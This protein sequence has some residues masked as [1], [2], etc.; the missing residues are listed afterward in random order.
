MKRKLE[1]P[2]DSVNI[3]N[4]ISNTPDKCD[5]T[6]HNL[7]ISLI[8][9]MF[10]GSARAG[11]IDKDNPVR[12]SS[13]RGNLRF[14]WRAT[15]GAA[16]KNV[17]ELSKRETEIF[18]NTSTPSSIHIWIERVGKDISLD[19]AQIHSGRKNEFVK[20]LPK[21][22]MFPFDKNTEIKFGS[23]Y[24]FS[25]RITVNSTDKELYEKEIEP[26][27]WAWINF[28]GVGAR[29]R[30][31]CGSL[32]S[33]KFSPKRGENIKD[34]YKQ[35]IAG[36]ELQLPITD[37]GPGNQQWPILCD[38]IK[39]SKTEETISDAWNKIAKLYSDFRRAPCMKYG[40]VSND[41]VLKRSFWPEAD[42]I[43]EITGMSKK[44]HKTS[45]TIDK[46]EY[47]FPRAQLGLPIQ[48]QFA[49]RRVSHE[50]KLNEPF[51]TK[52]LPKDKDRLASPLILKVIGVSPSA[53]K[54]SWGN[55]FKGH[56]I[57]AVLRQPMLNELSLELI[58]VKEPM[59][60][61]QQLFTDTKKKLQ[62]FK[63]EDN[64]IYPKTKYKDNQFRNPMRLENSSDYRRTQKNLLS[65]SSAIQA[66]LHSK[67]VAEWE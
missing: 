22:F 23:Q 10:G 62:G 29:T 40:G 47:A 55:A 34:W 42:S 5:V 27:L 3:S 46:K 6:I 59:E 49:K 32:Y 18:G 39:F 12:V 54:S 4:L 31:G 9:P 61:E 21:Y 66:F 17:S 16:F 8:S 24:T 43:R 33:E 15:R 2:D 52:L 41:N 63:I 44:E 14:W 11:V 30:R 65:T 19:N 38:D 56:A 67:E 13:V 58:D 35:N 1:I 25:L 37:S 48:F 20:G 7:T 36:Y 57:I 26:A 45:T 51:K 53:N 28:G 50:P 64:Y 60:H